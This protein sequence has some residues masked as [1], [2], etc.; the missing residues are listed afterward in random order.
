M[1]DIQVVLFAFVYDIKICILHGEWRS[2][3]PWDRSTYILNE[4]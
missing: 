3:V 4:I 1:I 2:I